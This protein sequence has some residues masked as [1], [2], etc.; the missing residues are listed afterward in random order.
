LNDEIR[1]LIDASAAAAATATRKEIE[2]VVERLE[3][4]IDLTVEA[5]RLLDAKVDRRSAV[6]DPSSKVPHA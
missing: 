4:K 1:A 2:T 3:G 6:I 5:L